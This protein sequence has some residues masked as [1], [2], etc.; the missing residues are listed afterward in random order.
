MSRPSTTIRPRRVSL[1]ALVSIIPPA[2]RTVVR[3]NGRTMVYQSRDTNVEETRREFSA[4]HVVQMF[5]TVTRQ[6]YGRTAQRS[7][8]RP[9]PAAFARI[10]HGHAGPHRRG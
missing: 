8:E 7:R 3:S 4:R 5:E 9:R 10:G 6:G 2:C 1:S